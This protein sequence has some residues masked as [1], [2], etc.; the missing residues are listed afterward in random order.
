MKLGCIFYMKLLKF[1]CG[2]SKFI[3]YTLPSGVRSV[4]VWP[5]EA[6]IYESLERVEFQ[7][8]SK[9]IWIVCLIEKGIKLSLNNNEFL[10]N[11]IQKA[12]ETCCRVK[13]NFE[14]WEFMGE[15]EIEDIYKYKFQ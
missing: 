2:E 5:S 14:L 4:S 15:E 11:I 7:Y 8:L 6:D 9:H 13:C 1:K 3:V 10:K 12:M